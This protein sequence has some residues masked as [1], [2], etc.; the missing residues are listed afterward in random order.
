MSYT[1]NIYKKINK[2]RISDDKKLISVAKFPDMGLTG[3]FPKI[4][5]RKNYKNTI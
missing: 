4:Q 2:C 1:K 5:K 3:T